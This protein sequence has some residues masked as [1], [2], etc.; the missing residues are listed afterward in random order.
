MKNFLLNT[1]GN[2]PRN[3]KMTE[4]K[5]MYF[6]WILVAF[7]LLF[8][9]KEIIATLTSFV[10]TP[11]YVARNYIETGTGNV[12]VFIRSR[13]DLDTQIS[14]LQQEL[15]A[16]QGMSATLSQM[17]EEN[18]ELR[19]LLHASATPRIAAGVIARPPYSPYDTFILD[20]GTDDGIQQYAPVYHGASRV[21]G[22]V[23]A[24]F[25]RSA[26]VIL[27]SSSGV[28]STAY[29][30]GPNIFTSIYGEG[31]GIMRLSIPQGIV[32]EKGNTVV[33]PSIEGGV[34]GEVFDVQ[35]VPTEP[36]QHAYISFDAPLVGIRLVSVGTRPIQK[37]DFKVAEQNISDVERALFHV[38]VPAEYLIASTTAS[39]TNAETPSP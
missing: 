11:V 25:E 16:N 17:R 29:V 14:N 39:T 26:L 33:L 3:S 28:E 27:F 18:K 7:V 10:T 1:K 36:E 19:S 15:S 4:S 34:L 5:R 2:Y 21:I 35:S 37:V 9:A 23:R 8:S 12:P 31:G 30:F 20:K 24:V 6:V 13:M 32:V 38:D 22:Y